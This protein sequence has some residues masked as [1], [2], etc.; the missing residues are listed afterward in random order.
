MST[1]QRQAENK[2]YNNNHNKWDGVKIWTF[3][4]GLDLGGRKTETE[5]LDISALLPLLLVFIDC[6]LITSLS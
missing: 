1:A 6:L 4:C 2:N 3:G 5:T